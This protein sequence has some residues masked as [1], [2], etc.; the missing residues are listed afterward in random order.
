MKLDR[1]AILEKAKSLG[2]EHH[3]T[4]K[5][6]AIA[7]MITDLTGEEFEAATPK[8]KVK[9]ADS[10]TIRAIIH[11]GDRENDERFA[12]FGINGKNINIEIGEEVDFPKIFL[13]CVHDANVDEKI[14][15]LD[16]K[17]E[18]TGKYKE[19]K[20]KNYILERI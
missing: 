19:R 5:T 17:G 10:D 9:A 7:K 3:K 20:R 2:I 14:A 1:A 8:G 18:V 11:S 12:Y 15:I 4:A 16:A 6:A 13:S